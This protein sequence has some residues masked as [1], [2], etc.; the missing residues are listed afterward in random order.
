MSLWNPW[1]ERCPNFPKSSAQVLGSSCHRHRR[2][3]RVR[4]L[5]A[6]G[7]SRASLIA[8]L[9]GRNSGDGP[10][11]ATCQMIEGFRARP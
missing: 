5:R 2:L 11:S 1:V 6:G 8:Y 4:I 9:A 3:Q 7:G 10:A